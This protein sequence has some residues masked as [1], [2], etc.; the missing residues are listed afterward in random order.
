M[1]E[2]LELIFNLFPLSLRLITILRNVHLGSTIQAEML[3]FECLV[4]E[5]S[6]WMHWFARTVSIWYQWVTQTDS[7]LYLPS[8]CSYPVF[9]HFPPLPA[10]QWQSR[11]KTGINLLPSHLIQLQNN[12]GRPLCPRFHWLL[13]TNSI[14]VLKSHAISLYLCVTRDFLARH[15][16]G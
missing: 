10:S 13:H 8:H 14:N 1:Q 9:I 12:A 11:K 2:R 15:I 7:T 16:E 3:V 4:A 6:H 5:T